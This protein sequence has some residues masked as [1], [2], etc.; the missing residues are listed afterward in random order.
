MWIEAAISEELLKGRYDLYLGE[1]FNR[2]E[3]VGEIH[4]PSV[5]F[6]RG[7]KH[8]ILTDATTDGENTFV[9]LPALDLKSDIKGLWFQ[10]QPLGLSRGNGRHLFASVILQTC[11]NGEWLENILWW[12]DLFEHGWNWYEGPMAN[13]AR[14]TLL[15]DTMI[16]GHISAHLPRL[17]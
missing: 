2:C 8:S 5:E 9:D 12:R 10:P 15:T 7:L 13:A 11:L 16:E 14:S 3:K 1:L 6:S 17:I 4:R